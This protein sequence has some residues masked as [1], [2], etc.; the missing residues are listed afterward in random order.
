[1]LFKTNFAIVFA[2]TCL[3][4]VASGDT[5]TVAPGKLLCIRLD[6][7]AKMKIGAG[8]S[9]TLSETV[10]V[11]DQIAIQTG[12]RFIGHVADIID[13]PTIKHVKS[14]MDGDFTPPHDAMVQFD[15]VVAAD[16]TWLPI[17]TSAAAGISNAADVTYDEGNEKSNPDP[18]HDREIKQHI[19]D[20]LEHK[21]P[22]HP[23]HVARGDVF[24]CELMEPLDVVS[25]GTA[26]PQK[27]ALLAVQ[28]LTALDTKSVELNEPIQAVVSEP[29]FSAEGKLLFPEGTKVA[30]RVTDAFSAGMLQHQGRLRLHMD[31]AQLADGAVVMLNGEV[32]GMESSRGDH[33]KVDQ[34]GDMSPSRSKIGIGK[35]VASVYGP[36][37]SAEDPDVAKTGY[38]RATRGLSGFGVI[39][40]AAAQAGP[41]TAT[42]FGAYGAAKAI[43]WTFIGPGKNVVLPAG[44]RIKLRLERPLES[45]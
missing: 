34:E 16:G 27:D 3:T 7:K 4:A 24:H 36:T 21:L 23:E 19:E 35:A 6:A 41:N 40:S 26:V 44:T 5:V 18:K 45:N 11:R 39:G 8:V 20:A 25:Q 13:G 28:L 43:Y 31:T 15:Y 33:M 17:H 9:G 14:V 29:Y 22:Y 2:S 1:M 42:G 10:Y 38:A 12:T 30:G 32:A 37:R